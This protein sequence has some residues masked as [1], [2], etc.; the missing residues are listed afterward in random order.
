MQIE[1]NA[2]F[3]RNKE[4]VISPDFSLEYKNSMLTSVYEKF[5]N[6]KCLCLKYVSNPPRY[7]SV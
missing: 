6:I 2:D 5:I 7:G 3:C 1:N 4:S